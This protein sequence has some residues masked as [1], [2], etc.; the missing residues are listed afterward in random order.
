M[1]PVLLVALGVATTIGTSVALVCVGLVLAGVGV[2][3]AIVAFVTVRQRLTPP[4]LQGRV[5]AASS[6]AYNVP[7]LTAT[8]LAAAVILALDYRLMIAVTVLAV[9][10]AAAIC[11]PR[12]DHGPRRVQELVSER[13]GQQVDSM[14]LRADFSALST[15]RL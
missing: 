2:S 14:L 13:S 4:T 8:V 11:L 10:A 3:W 12:R 1:G 9:L 5:S 6:M 15:V 7:Q